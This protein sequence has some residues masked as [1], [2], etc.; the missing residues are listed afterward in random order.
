[1]KRKLIR[2][3]SVALLVAAPIS[4]YGCG[5]NPSNKPSYDF[6]FPQGFGFD[7]DDPY[8][9]SDDYY[10]DGMYYL[11][12]YEADEPMTDALDILTM[13]NMPVGISFTK[14]E[15]T[16]RLFNNYCI[17][18]TTSS[19]SIENGMFKI[20]SK[21]TPVNSKF[22]KE[23]DGCFYL[24]Y[25]KD[26]KTYDYKYTTERAVLNGKY[27]LAPE[28]FKNAHFE[29]HMPTKIEF[30]GNEVTITFLNG[31]EMTCEYGVYGQMLVF[32]KN[33][34]FL[35]T[36]MVAPFLIYGY[37]GE[38]FFANSRSSFKSTYYEYIRVD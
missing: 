8:G 4:L 15:S 11:S 9:E 16:I 5:S 37:N 18:Y 36:T 25:K 35:L 2:F 24:E 29:N 10:L 30:K 20:Y 28:S 1:M 17:Y 6:S 32:E 31:T 3:I 26:D 21:T 12:M 34:D 19:Y 7:D 13:F 38:H 14:H 27:E 33:G 23:R 22:K